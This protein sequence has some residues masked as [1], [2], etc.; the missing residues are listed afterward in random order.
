MRLEICIVIKC[1]STQ[2]KRP[3]LICECCGKGFHDT[4]HEPIVLSIP[5]CA[6]YCLYCLK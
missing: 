1:K 6:W 4:C 2:I 3:M 5:K